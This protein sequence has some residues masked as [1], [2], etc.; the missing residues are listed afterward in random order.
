[1]ETSIERDAIAVKRLEAATDLRILFQDTDA[2]SFLRQSI[3]AFQAAQ[4]G[5]DNQILVFH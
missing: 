2:M 5:T 4:A 3:T 1:M